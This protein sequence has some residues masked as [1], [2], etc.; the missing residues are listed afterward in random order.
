MQD[1]MLEMGTHAII[2]M[3]MRSHLPPTFWAALDTALVQAKRIGDADTNP[4]PLN[5]YLAV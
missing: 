4:L 2:R 5:L 1:E 3:P